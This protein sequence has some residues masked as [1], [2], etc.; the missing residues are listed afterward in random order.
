MVRLKLSMIHDEDPRA[1]FR[2]SWWREF[3][4][5]LS[6]RAVPIMNKS[7]HIFSIEEVHNPTQESIITE[8]VR[9]NDDEKL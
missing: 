3:T 5:E 9:S 6:D 1:G 7:G 2:G 8:I 4:P